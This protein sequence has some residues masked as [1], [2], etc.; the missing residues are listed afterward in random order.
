M[1]K[2]SLT[3]TNYLQYLKCPEELWLQKNRPDLMPKLDVDALHKIEQGNYVDSLAREWF[4]D[5]CIL[6]DQNIDPEK[7]TFQLQATYEGL[8]AVADIVVYGKS[9]KHIQLFEAKAATSLKPEHLNDVAYQKYVFEKNGYIVTKTFLVHVNKGYNFIGEIAQCDL[10]AATDITEQVNEIT[11]ITAEQ[12]RG[13][14]QLIHGNMPKERI[15]VG[16]P[17]KLKC[18]FVQY[19]FKNIPLSTI[20]NIPNIQTKKLQTL[21]DGGIFDL[22]DVP[23]DFPLTDKQRRAVTIAHQDT[24]VIKTGPIKRELAK[25][26]YPLY[27]IDYESFSYIV[28]AQDHYRPYQQMVFQYS[29]HTQTS[30][31]AEVT[32]TEYLLTAKKESVANLLEHLQ[33]NVGDTGSLIV[34]NESFEKARNVEMASIHPEYADFLHLSLIHI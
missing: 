31:D 10:M 20:Y 13:A 11:D 29:L 8:V 22:Q 12:I 19:H 1:R 18:P 9:E 2:H 34:W 17:N 26:T 21:L 7:V 25:L 14:W 6:G 32:H 33:K 23:T 27:F 3:K 30:P 4:K 5:G 24:I 16:C 28:P 15:T